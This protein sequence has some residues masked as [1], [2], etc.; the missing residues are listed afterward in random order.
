[1]PMQRDLYPEDWEAIATRIKEEVNWECE[2]CGKRCRCPG[3]AIA[4]YVDRYFDGNAQ[5]KDTCGLIDHPQRDVLS[6]LKWRN[7]DLG[8][9]SNFDS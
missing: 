3:E 2:D 5:G 8:Q 4:D 1:M 9:I 7:C 6:P